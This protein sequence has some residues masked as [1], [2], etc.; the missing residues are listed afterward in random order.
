MAKPDMRKVAEDIITMKV[1]R[2]ASVGSLEKEF[3]KIMRKHGIKWG[4]KT[5][6]NSG[7]IGANFEWTMANALFRDRIV[8]QIELNMLLDFPEDLRY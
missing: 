5:P 1:G 3:Y 4:K 8:G 6:K 7:S 2:D